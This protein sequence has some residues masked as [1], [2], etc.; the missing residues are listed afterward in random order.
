[1]WLV[2]VYGVNG[3][4]QS[5]DSAVMMSP[6]AADAA[7][8]ASEQAPAGPVSNGDDSQQQAAV[9]QDPTAQVYSTTAVMIGQNHSCSEAIPPLAT[10]I[11]A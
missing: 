7:A 10:H 3:D 2:V 9:S 8:A 4:S 1:V 6:G 5:A 11:S